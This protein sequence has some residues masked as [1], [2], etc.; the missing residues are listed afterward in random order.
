MIMRFKGIK[1]RPIEESDLPILQ[2]LFND[3]EVNED[4]IGWDFPVSMDQQL[5]WFK[6]LKDK[7]TE[8][9]AMIETDAG[10]T[11]G[12]ISLS[13]LDYINRTSSINGA[14]ILKEYQSIGYGFKAFIAILDMI[15]RQLDFYYLEVRHLDSQ[16]VTKHVMERMRFTHEGTLRGRV[17]K[18]GIR[19]DI[20]IWSITAD[21]YKLIRNQMFKHDRDN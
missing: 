5:S 6:S 7:K 11:V 18:D 20:L 1:L 12:T 2:K 14:K 19:H 21:E 3:P 15:F 13:N 9:R 4:V 8:F 16:L 10:E 17:L